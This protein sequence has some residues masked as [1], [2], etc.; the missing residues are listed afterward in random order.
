MTGLTSVLMTQIKEYQHISDIWY[1]L[2]DVC[3]YLTLHYTGMKSV[4][5]PVKCRVPSWRT[6]PSTSLFSALKSSESSSICSSWRIRPDTHTH[7]GRTV[8][9]VANTMNNLQLWHLNIKDIFNMT[10]LKQACTPIENHDSCYTEQHNPLNTFIQSKHI[11]KFYL[12]LWLNPRAP[13]Q[14]C[15]SGPWGTPH[16]HVS[17]PAEK[18]WWD[19][20]KMWC[21]K[22]L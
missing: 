22:C 10:M 19:R 6:L 16:R 5:L 17:L 12:F 8:E 14:P 3:V 13:L 21:L 20:E 2:C 7:N 9:R 1:G 18:F 15:S 11:I 4:S